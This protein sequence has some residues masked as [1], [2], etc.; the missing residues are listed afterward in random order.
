MLGVL[1][2]RAAQ[3]PFADV[4]STR[5]FEPLGM[6]DTAFFA[7]DTSRLA[8]AYV[9]TP[10]GLEVWDPPDGQWSSAPAFADGA[11]GLVSTLDDLLAFARMFLGGGGPVLSPD[12]VAEMTRDQLTPTQRAGG[13]AFLSGRGWGFGQAVVLDGPTAGAFGWDGGFGTSWLV[14]PHRDL[15][16]IVLT[17]RLFESAQ[18]PAV[19]RDLQAAALTA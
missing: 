10:D 2:A 12:A 13:Q 6:C 15:T 11:A 16:V 17:Q 14:D 3:I 18:A 1:L 4:L 5:V 19:H 9:A 7:T 8:T